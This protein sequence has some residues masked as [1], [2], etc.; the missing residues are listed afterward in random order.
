MLIISF[1][2]QIKPK[3]KSQPLPKKDKNSGPL[4]KVVGASFNEIVLEGKLE[5]GGRRKNV[6]LEFYAPWCGHCKKLEPKYA[7][8]AKEL[9]QSHSESLIVANMDATSNDIPSN[10]FKVDGYPTIYFVSHKAS[11]D[12]LAKPLVVKYEG[13]GREVEDFKKF[14]LEQLSEESEISGD[15]AKDEL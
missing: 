2:G 5:S 1:S 13:Q 6:L 8:L 9:S 10:L 14:V 11:T 4:I 12:K 15:G 3:I 7:K